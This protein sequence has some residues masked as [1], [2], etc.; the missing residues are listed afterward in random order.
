M[1][2]VIINTIAIGIVVEAAGITNL[3][4]EYPCRRIV[5]FDGRLHQQCTAQH[6]GNVAI[7]TLY[8]L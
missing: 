6:V 4:I 3:V 2:S 5:G 7:K 1:Y 8:I